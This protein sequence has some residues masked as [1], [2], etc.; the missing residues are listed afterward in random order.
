MEISEYESDSDLSDIDE[1]VLESLVVDVEDE[2]V[3]AEA[4]CADGWASVHPRTMSLDYN[5]V[6]TELKNLASV[7]ISRVCASLQTAMKAYRNYSDPLLQLLMV[8]LEPLLANMRSLMNKN[9]P[10]GA[11]AVSKQELI[12]FIRV[13]LMLMFY[14]VTPTVLFD[15]EYIEMFP[16]AARCGFDLQRFSAMLAAL[17]RSSAGRTIHRQPLLC[18]SFQC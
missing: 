14:K 12:R 3:D 2:T 15:D 16:V 1:V 8:W 11:K 7:E 9:L 17:G 4:I 13:E 5:V 10:V 18:G 6:D